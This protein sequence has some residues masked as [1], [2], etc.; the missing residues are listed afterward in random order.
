M[1][2]HYAPCVTARR[3]VRQRKVGRYG[4]D[5]TKP[6]ESSLDRLWLGVKFAAL[7][8]FA[9]WAGLQSIYRVL[10][11]LQALDVLSG[12]LVAYRTR[13]LASSIGHAGL[14][15]KTMIWL[16]ILSVNLVV[17]ELGGLIEIPP[18]AIG[19]YGP[20]EFA[21]AGF[22][23]MEFVSIVENANRVGIKLPAVLVSGLAQA[24]KTLGYGDT[25]EGTAK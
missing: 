16:L 12:V 18:Q 9:W 24:K 3:T 22:T 11:I 4:L 19:R 1:V 10:M 7:A 21:A 2:D 17:V 25:E 15:R 5:T 13:T 6:M 8:L 14:R 23:F 20:A